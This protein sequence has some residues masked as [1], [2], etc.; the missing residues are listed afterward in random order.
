MFA[1]TV[2]GYGLTK[3]TLPYLSRALA[4]SLGRVEIRN[5]VVDWPAVLRLYAVL[6]SCYILATG[7]SLLALVGARNAGP[8][9]PA[10]E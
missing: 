2:I 6:A 9:R 5:A 7:F 4:V 1:G 8:L 10:E 3:V